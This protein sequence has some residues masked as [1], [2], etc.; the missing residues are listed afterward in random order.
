MK[1]VFGGSFDSPVKD[2]LEQG[3]TVLDSGCGTGSFACELGK[4]YPNSKIHGIDISLR[5][6]EAIRPPNCEFHVHNIIH[7]PIFPDNHFDFIHQRLLTLALSSSDWKRVCIPKLLLQI[8]ILNHRMYKK[9]VATLMRQL[10]PGGW[11]E[12]AE[13]NGVFHI[14]SVI[15]L[16]ESL[17]DSDITM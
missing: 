8:N 9:V 17:I 1:L 12:L 4:E 6:P 7:D 10:K 14:V 2:A 16:I 5:V 15:N 11:I 13:V 3:I